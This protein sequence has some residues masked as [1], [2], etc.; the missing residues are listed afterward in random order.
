MVGDTSFQRYI[1]ESEADQLS[2]PEDARRLLICSGQVYYQLLKEREE[3][4]VKDVHIARMEQ[5]S[6]LPY[7]LLSPDLDRYPNAEVYW[8]QEEVSRI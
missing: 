6:P 5:L 7:E 1:P 4:G 3:K 2:S 8:V